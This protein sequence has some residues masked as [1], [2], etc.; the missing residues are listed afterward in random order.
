[1]EQLRF[2]FTAE[3]EHP[4]HGKA[5]LTISVPCEPCWEHRL[6][7]EPD[8]DTPTPPHVYSTSGYHT[9][10]AVCLATQS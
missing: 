3:V 7:G 10:Y 4:D 1:M 2:T 9:D 5:T 8:E 6:G